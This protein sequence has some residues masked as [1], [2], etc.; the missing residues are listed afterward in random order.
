M[1]RLKKDIG[2]WGENQACAFLGRQGFEIID[3]NYHTTNGEIDIVARQGGD[4]YFIEVK[5]RAEGDMANDLSITL[6]K[7]FRLQKTVK[8]YCYRKGISD[9]SIILSGLLVTFS[10]VHHTAR[11]SLFKLY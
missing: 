9:A 4:Y 1:S 3:R 5:T 10:R 11:F 2:D 8:S 6:S 7:K